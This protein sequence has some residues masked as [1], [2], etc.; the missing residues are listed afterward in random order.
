MK[1]L[2]PLIICCLVV[3]ACKNDAP[4]NNSTTNS[5]GST[6]TAANSDTKP[7]HIKASAIA[8]F[9]GLWSYSMPMSSDVQRTK[10]YEGRWIQFAADQTFKNGKWKNQTN[11]GT[12]EYDEK[13]NIL[14]LRFKNQK[15]ATMD[16]RIK[17]GVDVMIWLG[18]ADI[19]QTGD[20][21]RMQK[22]QELPENPN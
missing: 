7:R 10:D 21:I 15:D 17:L 3:F 2:W 19:N 16:W 12:F 11:T 22:I 4:T 6:T 9:I 18:N 1:K 20:Q 14:L 8:P 13:T 5:T